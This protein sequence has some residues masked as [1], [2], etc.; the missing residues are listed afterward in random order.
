MGH[1][2]GG[3]IKE[4]RQLIR[5]AAKFAI[6]EQGWTKSDKGVYMAITIYLAPSEPERLHY[7]PNVEKLKNDRVFA[8]KSPN[9]E[10]IAT[11]VVNALTDLVY[12]KAKQV[13]GLTVV[14]KFAKDPRIEVLIGEPESFKELIYDL[15]N[16]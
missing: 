9:I 1:S 11:L 14:K 4:F 13:I 2:G 12:D 16:A 6:A 10:R 15:R 8:I 5:M 3:G 7:K